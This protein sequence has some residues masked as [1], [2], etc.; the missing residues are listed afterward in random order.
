MMLLLA[1]RFLVEMGM[2]ICLGIGGLQL[3]GPLLVSVVLG[4]SLP[5]AAAGMWGRR[6]APRASRRLRDP[7]R[8]GVEVTLFTA[9]LLAVMPAHHS[10]AMAVVGLAVWAA[11]VASI[12]ARRHER[13]QLRTV[14]AENV[15]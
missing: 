2:L 4:V 8:L 14:A 12:P 9:A 11:F 10:S 13:V 7:F 1:V 5:L 6:V 15:Q 3:G